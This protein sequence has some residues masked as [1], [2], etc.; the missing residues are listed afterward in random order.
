MIYLNKVKSMNGEVMENKYK[1]TKE[2][3][4]FIARKM[5]VNNI[6]SGAKVEGVNITFPETKAIVDGANVGRLNMDEILVIHNLKAA[7]KYTLNNIDKPLDLDF[8]CR[9]NEDVSRDE[10][11]AW[12]VLRTGRVG[13]G[14]TDYV[15]DIPQEQAVVKDIDSIMSAENSATEKALNLYCF[16]CRNQL[17]WDGNKRTAFIVANKYLIDNGCG[18][19]TIA[20]K[21]I[22]EFNAK[23]TN[24]YNSEKN[25]EE[26]KAFLYNKCLN[27]ASFAEPIN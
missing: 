8:I 4:M 14:G 20:D 7:W 12:G 25:I 13:I 5:V 9:I 1:L 27:S 6:Y 23:L 19:L 26:L 22:N 18:L 10:S 21:D 3:N 15:P 11:L 16:L 17:F 24:Y 2:Q